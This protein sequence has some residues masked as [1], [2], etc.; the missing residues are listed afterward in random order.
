[1]MNKVSTKWIVML[2]AMMVVLSAC[3]GGNQANKGNNQAQQAGN[4]NKQEK[5]TDVTLVLNWSPNTNHTGLYVARDKGFYA[6]QGLNVDIIL[7]GS[8]GPNAVVGSGQAQFGVSFQEGVTDARLQEVPVVSIAAVIQHNTAVF[9]APVEKNIKAPKDFAGKT[10]GGFGAAA[11]PAIIEAL[12]VADGVADASDV[13][14]LNVGEADFFTSVQRDIDFSWIYYGWA[15]IEAELRGIEIDTIFLK[16]YS[17]KL[18]YYTPV[19][20]SNEQ[21]IE[22]KPEL[23]KAFMAATTAGYEYAI[24]HPDESARILLDAV[25][26]LDEE[27]VM[28]S[29]K[30]LSPRYQDDAQQWGVQKL[31]VWENYAK[32]LQEYDL[33]DGTFDAAAAFTNAFLPKAN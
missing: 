14:I 31:E 21:T 30:W 32:W 13:K 5:L 16:D 18:D 11:E 1:M 2:L 27:L 6:E 33:L 23:V 9:A 24:A 20:I 19:I 29:Q 17:H 7:P 4:G 22:Q 15:G 26:E 8:S 25:P 10:F 28:A 3:A 12:M